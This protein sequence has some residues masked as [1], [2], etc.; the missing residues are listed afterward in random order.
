MP[1]NFYVR[2][3]MGGNI[4]VP[5]TPENDDFF[6]VLSC[7]NGHGEPEEEQ[8]PKALNIKKLK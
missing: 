5:S 2:L 8:K 7:G 4:P 3:K 1:R 6:A